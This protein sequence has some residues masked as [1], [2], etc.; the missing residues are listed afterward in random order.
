M[1]QKILLSACLLFYS[2]QASA[3]YVLTDSNYLRLK[4]LVKNLVNNSEQQA[5][6]L[7]IL[8]EQLNQSD[9]QVI[10]LQNTIKQVSETNLKLEKSLNQQLTGEIIV[11]VVV[12]V[13]SFG[14]GALIF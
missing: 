9:K 10:E 4:V 5:A 13:V 3:D 11:V 2:L 1:W 7:I 12:A 6:L 14:L 8:T